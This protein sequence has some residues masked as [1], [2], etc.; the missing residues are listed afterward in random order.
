MRI[1]KYRR[2]IL[3]VKDRNSDRTFPDYFS[4]MIGWLVGCRVK[5]NCL[6][7]ESGPLGTFRDESQTN[8]NRPMSS[9]TPKLNPFN[10][11]TSHR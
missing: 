7:V 4:G 3:S 10:K 8:C 6:L 9:S 5:V 11:F 2:D 1:P